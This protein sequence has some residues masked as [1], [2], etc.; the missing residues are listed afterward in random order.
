MVATLEKEDGK[1][2][3][4]NLH[5]LM[6]NIESKEEEELEKLKGDHKLPLESGTYFQAISF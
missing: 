4:D 2:K 3:I 1:A 5:K 6:K